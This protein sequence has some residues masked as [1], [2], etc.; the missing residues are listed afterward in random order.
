MNRR[1]FLALTAAATMVKTGPQ[2]SRPN[3]LVIL[4][5]QFR[6]DA[7]GV[8]GNSF[9]QTPHLDGLAREGVRFSNAYCPQA[10]C[11]PSRASLFTGVYPHTTHV[12]HN[13][14]H[15]PSAFAL[16]QYSLSPNW[17][18]LLRNAGYYTGYIG[19]WHLGEDNPGFFDYWAGYNSLKPHWVGERYR[20]AYRTDVE[21]DEAMSFLEKNRSKPFALVVSH[22]PP[23]TPYDPPLHDEN[24][25][26]RWGVPIPGYYGAVTAVDRAVGRV[27]AKLKALNLDRNTF[28]CF[29]SDH[30]ET[31]GER[32][33][34]SDKGVCYD[35]SAKVPF[36]MRYPSG[37]PS[38][39]VYE[40][41]V[42][43]IDL[44]PTLLELAGISL[45]QRLQ[46]HSRLGEIRKNDLGWKAP[47]FMENISQ[48]GIGGTNSIERGV[49]TRRW[50]LILRDHPKDEL[51]NLEADPGESDDLLPRPESHARVKELA[52][53]MLRWSE[54]VNDPIAARLAK[55]YA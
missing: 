43:T 54:R 30:G 53:L 50:K 51:Y 24:L 41:G 33:G 29:T 47:V 19:K 55:R 40:G 3:V 52:G 46:G 37:L 44:M 22:Y 42:S 28:V 25:Y 21:A 6:A 35:D 18:S 36:L 10:L 1:D 15:V 11:S 8:S 5:D 2:T 31:F 27:L 48:R 39:V 4:A 38:G 7:L 20:S 12:E 16:S 32:P 17:P 23:H 14:Y 45:P 26:S 9:T 13:I 34:S 49:R